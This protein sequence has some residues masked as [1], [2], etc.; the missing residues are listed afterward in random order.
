MEAMQV[1]TTSYCQWC[2]HEIAP[3]AEFRE[4]GVR[5]S[6]S[7]YGD[8][9]PFRYHVMLPWASFALDG[10]L[11]CSGCDL[12]PSDIE[13]FRAAA[14]ALIA[15]DAANR[16]RYPWIERIEHIANERGIFVRFGR[17][18][19]GG[20]STNFATGQSEGGLS[21][22]EAELDAQTATIKLAGS[23]D[24]G[25]LFYCLHQQRVVYLVTG[26]RV[27]QGSDGEPV[28]AKARILGSLTWSA[29]D[30]GFRFQP[31]R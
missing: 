29:T 31:A 24:P 17:A 13:P 28:I 25:T 23:A 9:Y 11:L 7:H 8:I 5:V 22:Y 20:C 26:D 6:R 2:K 15:Q 18:P 16:Q 12:A 4:D 21:V 30:E 27:G 14:L 3:I 19:K 10:S 1:K